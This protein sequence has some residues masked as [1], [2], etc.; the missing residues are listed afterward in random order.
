MKVRE[1]A[2]HIEIGMTS[3]DKY[4]SRLEHLE[5]VT[6]LDFL[7]HYDFSGYRADRFKK[8]PRAQPR[9]LNYFPLY[10][11]QDHKDDL[12]RVKM[13]LHHPFRQVKDLLLLGDQPFKCWSDA[14][15]YCR[16]SGCNFLQLCAWSCDYCVNRV[17]RI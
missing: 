10:K 13:L 6:F 16:A 2:E 17:S 8:R 9:V 5:T 12:A 4:K 11:A 1:G 14:Y 15:A 3:L 7:L